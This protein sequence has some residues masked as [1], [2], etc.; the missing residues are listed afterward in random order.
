[1][2]IPWFHC[3][4]HFQELRLTFKALHSFNYS[5][6]DPKMCFHCF[7][8]PLLT[9][10]A[11]EAPGATTKAAHTTCHGCP[12]AQHQAT[13]SVKPSVLPK[14]SRNFRKAALWACT[15]CLTPLAVSPGGYAG[16]DL[17][18]RCSPLPLNAIPFV[19]PWARG[20][21]AMHRWVILSRLLGPAGKEASGE[22]A[23]PAPRDV[24]R[25]VWILGP[26]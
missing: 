19:V 10:K 12:N 25:Q 14:F 17:S 3:N 9:A 21:H 15:H 20:F 11:Q 7:S 5:S 13:K 22:W 4:L 23:P 16:G 2:S 18:N 24:L 1:M 26:R 6:G 8:L